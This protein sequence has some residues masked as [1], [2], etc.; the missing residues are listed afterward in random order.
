MIIGI[1]KVVDRYAKETIPPQ[2][3]QTESGTTII[4]NEEEVEQTEAEKEASDIADAVL[5]DD[6][7]LQDLAAK[8][9]EESKEDTGPTETPVPTA[10]PAPTPSPTPTPTPEPTLTPTPSPTPTPTPE[11]E[12][13]E[14]VTK[15][16]ST[17]Q[18]V[19]VEAI[20]DTEFEVS[21]DGGRSQD[22]VM[23]AGSIRVFKSD[24]NIELELE[25]AG[26][27]KVTY[28]G[29]D[30]GSLGDSGKS[31]DLKFPK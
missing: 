23:K 11:A 13:K 18:E 8:K 30:Q 6:P 10:T 9:S 7:F 15:Q 3:A 1:K 5:A 4:S 27:V 21:L 17:T 24:K 22:I 14:E 12:K 20:S 26:A 31:V 19:I 28:N 16:A 29:E 2:T 25:D